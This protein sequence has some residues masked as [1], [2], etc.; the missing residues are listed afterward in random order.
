MKIALKLTAYVTVLS[1]ATVVVFAGPCEDGCDYNNTQCT[2]QANTTYSQCTAAVQAESNLCYQQ[3]D[4]Q[5]ST[6]NAN[7]LADWA[8]CML[9]SHQQEQSICNSMLFQAWNS[10]DLGLSMSYN[11]CMS[12]GGGDQEACEFNFQQDQQSCANDYDNCLF[13]CSVQNP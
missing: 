1:I 7:A 4:E 10:C 3:A 13:V 8:E 2:T 5:W 12:I 9:T 6:C 11:Y